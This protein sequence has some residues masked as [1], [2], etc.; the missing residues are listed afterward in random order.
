MIVVFVLMNKRRKVK[1]SLMDVLAN[2]SDKNPINV[3]TYYDIHNSLDILLFA[4]AA[5]MKFTFFSDCFF[6]FKRK[7][8]SENSDRNNIINITGSF[9]GFRL[10]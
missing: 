1:N 9:Y 7:S 8:W 5:S 4:F 3:P 10:T 6:S 2:Y